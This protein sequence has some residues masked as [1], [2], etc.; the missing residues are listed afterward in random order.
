MVAGHTTPRSAPMVA[1]AGK[2][3][4]KFSLFRPH[5]AE[6]DPSAAYNP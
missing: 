2:A 3:H 6:H 5:A 4:F 1:G